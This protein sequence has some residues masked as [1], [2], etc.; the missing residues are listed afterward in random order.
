MNGDSRTMDV[1]DHYV[2]V[3]DQQPL[4]GGWEPIEAYYARL[5][6][7]PTHSARMAARAGETGHVHGFYSAN[8]D[9]LK[10]YDLV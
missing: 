4:I 6:D 2:K 8:R 5:R 9:A 7:V 3:S 1:T 10:H